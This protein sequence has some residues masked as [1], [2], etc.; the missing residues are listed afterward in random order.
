[1]YFI[2]IGTTDVDYGEDGAVEYTSLAGV[3]GPFETREAATT[4]DR[5]L[6]RRPGIDKTEVVHLTAP[7]DETQLWENLY[8]P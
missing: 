1:M 2:I 6:S 7:G 5:R 3:V 8:A 4:H